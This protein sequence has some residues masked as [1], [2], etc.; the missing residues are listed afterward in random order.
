MR[1]PLFMRAGRAILAGTL[2]S[3]LALAPALAH[4]SA[5]RPVAPAGHPGLGRVYGQPQGFGWWTRYGWNGWRH[6]GW[7]RWNSNAW[8]SAGQCGW[9]GWSCNAW[10][11]GQASFYDSG[12]WGGPSWGASPPAVINVSD[13]PVI[14]GAPMTVNVYG[15]GLGGFDRGYQ[16]AC[17]IHKLLY[18]R[19]GKYLGERQTYN[20]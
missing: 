16:G 19:D 5:L 3:A 9:N 6:N 14:T 15:G 20:C 8:N 10:T 11:W 1:I 7:N 17:V 18:D 13:P 12:Y 4:V 2:Y